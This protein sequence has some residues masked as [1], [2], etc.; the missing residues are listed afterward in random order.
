VI[1]FRER[2]GKRNRAVR[3]RK[4]M[5]GTIK[6]LIERYKQ[7]DGVQFYGPAAPDSILKIEQA[8]GVKLPPTF[9]DFLLLY[10]GGG[11]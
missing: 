5:T 3:N 11:E 9:R 10:G 1:Q 8:L 2:S 4:V 6:A 7:Q